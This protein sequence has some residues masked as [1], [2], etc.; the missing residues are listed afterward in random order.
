MQRFL[1]QF[2]G[3]VRSVN[4][5]S[6]AAGDVIMP[7]VAGHFFRLLIE[8]APWP[9]IA[10]HT[11]LVVTFGGMPLKNT[12]IAYGGVARHRAQDGLRACQ[13]AGVEF[14]YLGPVRNDT[15]DFLGAEWLTPRPN[16]D[17]AFMLGLAHTLVAEGLND[18]TFL[19]RCCVGFEKF[20][21]YLMGD[22]DNDGQPK[23]ADWAATITGVAAETIRSLARRM[24][25][26]RT[27]ITITWSMQ[28]AD[29][30]EQPYWMLVTLA[31]IL[32]QI[33]YRAVALATAMAR[34]Q[35]SARIPIG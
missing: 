15:A 18:E 4:T 21:P 14:V 7:Y 19:T 3:F 28:R 26:K 31:A 35:P 25:A 30:G 1:G 17:V 22:N 27:L 12:Q 34:S 13:Q 29:H 11:K 23:D 24:A 33:V 5:Y 20:R 9:T 2:G 32:G 10:K 16:T 8:Q 6:T